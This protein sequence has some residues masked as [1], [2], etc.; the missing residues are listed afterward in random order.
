MF[1]TPFARAMI[2]KVPRSVYTCIYRMKNASEFVAG[3][4]PEIR[5]LPAYNSG[6]SAEYV[7]ARYGVERVAKLGS[8]ENPWGTSPRVLAAVSKAVQDAALYP[9]PGSDELRAGLARR[10]SVAPE[11]FA[12]GNGSEDLISVCAHSFL[13]PGDEM[14]TIL[15]SFGLHVIYAQAI[16]ATVRQ[17]RVG[18]DYKLRIEDMIAALTPQTR[19]VMFSS[20]SNPLGTSI[21][22]ADLESLLGA[23]GKSTLLVFDEAYFEYAAMESSYP[24]FHEVLEN[25]GATWILLRTFSKA[26]GLA[27]LRIG[28]GVASE[29]SL[30]EVID[31]ARTPFNVN[32]LAQVAATAAL[33]EAGFVADCVKKTIEE[34]ERLRGALCRLG[35]I[36]APSVA[37][38]LFF[39]ARENADALAARLVKDGVIVKPWREPGYTDHI[40]VSIG[41]PESNDQFLAALAR[42]AS[43]V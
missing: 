12:F 19:M 37:N 8:N 27:G 36:S 21:T 33:E 9:D 10:L 42:S 1:A 15:P 13:G 6:L 29:A 16:G 7:R 26:Y 30:I 34:R 2:D 24:G 23:L 43:P 20:P 31:R 40:R 11:R 17:V 35:Y 18:S 38:F 41:S 14:V 22:R 28:Y 3:L 32:R 4:R 25:S 39:D 5:T